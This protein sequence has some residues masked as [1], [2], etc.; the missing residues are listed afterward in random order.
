MNFLTKNSKFFYLTYG[1]LIGLTIILGVVFASQ[2][3]DIRVTYTGSG[4]SLQIINTTSD[5]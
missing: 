3:Y 5:S 4:D 1:I 2:Y